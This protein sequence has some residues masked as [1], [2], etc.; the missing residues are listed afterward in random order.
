[1][2][3][4]SNTTSVFQW[5]SQE[6]VWPFEKMPDGSTCYC[7]TVS[8]GTISGQYNT[9]NHNISNFTPAKLLRMWCITSSQPLPWFDAGTWG[10]STDLRI[11]STQIAYYQGSGQS[12]NGQTAVAYLIY[13]K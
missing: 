10:N 4:I 5:S 8:L 6:Q 12:F 2:I 3:R 7:K 13:K 11:G 9:V 1:M